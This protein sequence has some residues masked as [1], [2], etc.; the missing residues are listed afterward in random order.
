[1]FKKILIISILLILSIGVVSASE[2]VTD[3]ISATDVVAV[4]SDVDVEKI[5]ASDEDVLQSTITVSGKTF[6]D[7]E[8]AIDKAKANDVIQLSGTYTCSESSIYVDKSIT[9]Q[10]DSNKATLDAKG[11]T[12]IIVGSYDA[13]ITLKNII[14]K[15]SN[16]FAVI[17]N[18]GGSIENCNFESN[19]Y[20]ISCSDSSESVGLTVKNS[21]FNNNRGTAIDAE[22]KSLTVE[23]STFTNNKD[24]AINL[25]SVKSTTVSIKDSTFTGN[26]ATAGSAVYGILTKGTATINNCKFIN[27]KASSFAGAIS[28]QADETFQLDILGSTFNSNSAT[29]RSSALNLD[30]TKANIKNNIFIKNT[31]KEDEIKSV[32]SIGQRSVLQN[33]IIK[34]DANVN[35]KLSVEFLSAPAYFGDVFEVKFTKDGGALANKKVTILAYKQGTYTYENFNAVTDAN[36]VAK[37]AFS[38]DSDNFVGVWDIQAIADSGSSKI[39]ASKNNINVKQLDAQIVSSDLTTTYASGKVLTLKLVNKNTNMIA[40]GVG[41]YATIY[42]NGYYLKNVELRTNNNGVANLKLSNLATANYVVEINDEGVIDENMKLAKASFKVKINK[43]PTKVSAPKVTNKF[44]KSKYF[45]VTVK[46][47]NKPVKKLKV[48]VKVF[49]GKKSK[50]YTVTTNA[51]GVAQLNTKSL[52]KGTHK[53]ELSSGNGNYKISAKSTIKIN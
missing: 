18:S 4:D 46:A 45:K 47:Y 26:S 52:S 19:D 37:F 51:K 44:K 17:I 21:A 22:V 6:D 34:E 2:N 28:L 5:S 38:L 30:N 40:G 23:K 53:V 10:G 12:S 33:N 48:K 1:M 24:S 41:L 49:T 39:L 20:G 8:N 29:G 9:I 7:I 3:D 43:A 27:N 42:K 16:D 14:F 32:G 36:G 11:L 15:N 35:E 50:T 31:A 25:Y 13:K